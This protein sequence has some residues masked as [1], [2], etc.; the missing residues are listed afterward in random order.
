MYNFGNT[1]LLSGLYQNL[2]KS[3]GRKCSGEVVQRRYS[4]NILLQLVFNFAKIRNLTNKKVRSSYG[5]LL[6]TG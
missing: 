3:F 1:N 5:N 6:H 4:E 2:S